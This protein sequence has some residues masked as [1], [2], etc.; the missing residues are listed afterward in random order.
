M[1]SN[2][3]FLAENRHDLILSEITKTGFVTVPEMAQKLN[4]SEMTL[5]RD[6]DF[7]AEQNRLQRSHGG[8]V[9]L[10]GSAGEIDLIEPDVTTRVDLHASEKLRIAHHA[11]R[12]AIG[13][14]FIALDIGTT[15][16]ALA[17]LLIDIPLRLFT[18]SVKI[19]DRLARGRAQLYM[20]GGEV[21]GIEPSIVGARAIEQIQ[22]FHF[23]TFFL[24]A[25]SLSFDGIY[26]YSLEDTEVKRT[27]IERSNRVIALIDSSK[28]ERISVAKVADFEK[29]DILIS[30]ARPS[31][32]LSKAL[33]QAGV[34]VEIAD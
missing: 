6:L 11:M 2:R 14:E 16:L 34:T 7:L 23:S 25:S 22:S 29:I 33:A 8:A 28:F 18:S 5:R 20:P 12:H 15:N 13:D 32:Q 1:Q 21:R 17:K 4:V 30:D 9:S 26:D 3:K 31:A 19:A 10:N 24:G 27:L